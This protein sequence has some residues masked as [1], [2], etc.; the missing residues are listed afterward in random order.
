MNGRR[1]PWRWRRQVLHTR[2]QGVTIQNTTNHIFTAVRAHTNEVIIP[3]VCS[4]IP[5]RLYCFK[6]RYVWWG[7]WFI[8]AIAH[9]RTTSDTGKV[10]HNEPEWGVVVAFIS[11]ALN[12]SSMQTS[13]FIV[14][15]AHRG[16]SIHLHCS[17]A[18]FS[19]S[20]VYKL[21]KPRYQAS[22]FLA[23][24]P[25]S[26]SFIWRKTNITLVGTEVSTMT[27]LY[28]VLRSKCL[29]TKFGSHTQAVKQTL[30]SFHIHSKCIQQ[31]SC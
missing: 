22:R 9:I 11:F 14:T 19:S 5:N 30:I 4:S 6:P 26:S 25:S 13:T 16:L 3:T 8:T 21:Q 23:T 20:D 7:D 31:N 27:T 24:L 17:R 15:H 10:E 28:V 2:V 18:W 12:C 1:K 29:L